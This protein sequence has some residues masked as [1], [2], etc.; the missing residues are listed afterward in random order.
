MH[1][2]GRLE[3]TFLWHI[4]VCFYCANFFPWPV[5]SSFMFYITCRRHFSTHSHT[6]LGSFHQLWRGNLLFFLYKL[7]HQILSY[8]NCISFFHLIFFLYTDLFGF[9]FMHSHNELLSILNGLFCLGI[10]WSHMCI[11]RADSA[12]VAI[13]TTD[14]VSKSVAVET[15]VRRLAFPTLLCLLWLRFLDANIHYSP[16]LY[17]SLNQSIYFGWILL[18]HY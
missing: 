14:L 8:N 1:S 12:A 10:C 5:T 3:F 17:D 16:N 7:H 13:T 4:C 15:E 11:C 18:D 6:L 2:V 9:V